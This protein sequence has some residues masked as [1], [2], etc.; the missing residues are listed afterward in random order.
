MA[1]DEM[2]VVV[3]AD[4]AGYEREMRRAEKIA[5]RFRNQL[6][7]RIL[8]GGTAIAAGAAF[9]RGIANR[10]EELSQGEKSPLDNWFGGNA[11]RE[12]REGLEMLEKKSLT[13]KGI[14]TGIKDLFAAGAGEIAHQIRFFGIDSATTQS[15]LQGERQRKFDAEAERIENAR[16]DKERIN[17]ME[18][19]SKI[20]ET[21]QG[22]IDETNMTEGDILRKKIEQAAA[23][24]KG[25]EIEDSKR[26]ALEKVLE[27]EDAIS[28][29]KRDQQKSAE[30]LIELERSQQQ[31]R[32]DLSREL[33]REANSRNARREQL[34]TDDENER[35]LMLARSGFGDD[36]NPI[37][38]FEAEIA[39][40]QRQRAEEIPRLAGLAVRGSQQ[41]AQMVNAARNQSDPRHRETINRLDEQIRQ[42]RE[43]IQMARTAL[44]PPFDV[45]R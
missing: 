42:L 23:G 9:V 32:E 38:R 24:A 4:I 8:G 7:G 39:E 29:K 31:E 11:T 16:R 45:V 33:E 5:E 21:L 10:M 14:W 28:R 2:S 13:I 3:K 37:A 6:A 12:A 36:E 19:L 22:K 30:A 40:L 27:L 25:A 44:S 41:E 15:I 26:G 34:L 1:L 35:R 20:T 43:L 18:S 17:A